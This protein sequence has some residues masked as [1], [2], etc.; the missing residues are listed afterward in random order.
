MAEA[1]I[2]RTGSVATSELEGFGYA[3]IRVST[4]TGRTLTC[5]NNLRTFT[6]TCGDSGIV[7]FSVGYGK[8]T[9]TTGASSIEV[10]IENLQIYNVDLTGNRTYGIKID[11]TNTSPADAVTYTD[12][13]IG[14]T[15]L[16]VN[17][18]TGACNYGS[19]GEQD[20]IENFLGCRPCLYKN[21]ARV[22][23]L[24]PNDYSKFTNGTTAD[25]TSGSA[26]D[27]MVEFKKLWYKFSKVDSDIYFQIADYDRS[28][29]GFVTTAFTSEDDGHDVDYMYY[30]AYEGCLDG[31]KWRSLSDKRSTLNINHADTRTYCKNNGIKYGMENWAKRW[32]ILGLL[33]LVCKGRDMSS[34]IGQ[35]CWQQSSE[36]HAVSTG[37]MNSR[38]LFYGRSIYTEGVKCF[39]IENMWGNYWNCIDGV[40]SAGDA[41]LFKGTAP[42][43]DAGS[44]YTSVSDWFTRNSWNTI[45]NMMPVLNGAA[46]TAIAGQYNHTIGWADGWYI[47]H[48]ANMFCY[49]G[50]SWYDDSNY[51]LGPFVCFM[52][53]NPGNISYTLVGRLVAA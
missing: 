3:L 29:D 49:V 40:V 35:G 13:A 39:G 9:I 16:S 51:Y 18:S 23:Y 30:G 52:Y 10:N 4:N 36:S 11:T 37:S 25:I 20:F 2:T 24:N 6:K 31:N 42:Y 33:M 43:N 19:W 34:T 7:E 17:Q 50:G 21:G 53:Y 5:T 44:G 1:I 14:F 27:V 38:G 8:W 28:E 15:P 32:Y 41:L 22:G 45:I 46:M 48:V 12:D 26:G 47:S